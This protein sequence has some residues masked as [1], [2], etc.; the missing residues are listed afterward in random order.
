MHAFVGPQG[1][2]AEL[3]RQATLHLA[4]AGECYLVGSSVEVDPLD[5][6]T[7]EPPRPR[8]RLRR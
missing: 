6:F 1:G 5:E 2:Q 4:T 3:K 8:G 7:R